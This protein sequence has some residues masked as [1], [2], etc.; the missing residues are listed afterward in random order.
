MTYYDGD[1]GAWVKAANTLKMK[2]YITTR[3]VDGSAISKFNAIVASGNYISSNAD[4]FQFRWGTN[5]AIQPD[6]R[7]PRY[8]SS[9][10]QLVVIRI[11]QIL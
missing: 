9:Y 10:T 7:H 3:L 1:W 11:C 8:R 4:D 6:S 2:A 5:E